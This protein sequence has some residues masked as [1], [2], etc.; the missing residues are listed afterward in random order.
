MDMNSV[1]FY[2]KI[3]KEGIRLVEAW[4]DV[5][6]WGCLLCAYAEVSLPP[7]GPATQWYSIEFIQGMGRGEES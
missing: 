5:R 3:E 4:Y 2:K 6:E 7:E 1:V